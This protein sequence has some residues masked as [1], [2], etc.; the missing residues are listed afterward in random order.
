VER[1]DEVGHLA[2]ACNEMVTDLEASRKELVRAVDRA[3]DA[4]RL[5]GEFL[6][7]MSHEIR[8]PINGVIGMTEVLLE[9]PLS[10]EQREYLDVVSSSAQSLLGIV[11][12]ILDFSKIEAGKLVFDPAPFQ[13]EAA[14]ETMIRPLAVQAEKKDLD[15]LYAVD[16]GIPEWLVGDAA[17]LRQI[18]TNLVGNAIKFT[19]KGTV[20][21]Q[22]SRADDCEEPYLHFVVSDTGIG[23]DPARQTA[24]F[25][26]FYQADGSHSRRYGGTGLGLA[27]VARL[28][29]LMDGR[30]WVE[31]APGR[32]SA[33]H[34]TARFGACVQPAATGACSSD[35]GLIGVRALVAAG[36]ERLR[37]SL[38]K[39]LAAWAMDPLPAA[40]S[41]EALTLVAASAAAG[42]R[43]IQVL[44]VDAALPPLDGLPLEERILAAGHPPPGTVILLRSRE[45]IAGGVRR[46]IESA[47]AY[48]VKPYSRAALRAAIAAALKQAEPGKPENPLHVHCDRVA[49]EN[50]LTILIA[51]DNSVNALVARRLVESLGHRVHHA[52]D[53]SAALDAVEHYRYDVILMDVQMS[54]MDGL[55]ATRRMREQGLR[56]PI[57][58]MT[59]H[60]INGDR[61][62]CLAAGMDGY[63]SKPISRCSLSAALAAA[64]TSRLQPAPQQEELAR[65]R[66]FEGTRV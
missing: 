61:E 64:V 57:I 29:G 32:G 22:V 56:I 31:S 21:L 58:A 8:T 30:V 45:L 20:A 27:I 51:E 3:Q 14:L 15:L 39:M 38:S 40:T 60:A 53:G 42:Q 16:A 26:A 6:A 43:P 5:K 49:P 47:G 2:M 13:L 18:V 28:V 17:R 34:F 46:R 10:R 52:S 50:A 54:P 65:P 4:S 48:L 7:N 33:F 1:N 24:I 59:A 36:D 12:E 44:L 41:A 62:I 63:V 25:D 11:N 19:E 66:L 55:E 9:T 23:I 37:E 35:A